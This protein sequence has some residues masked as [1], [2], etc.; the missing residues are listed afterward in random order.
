MAITWTNDYD[1]QAW[2]GLSTQL[3]H[4][5]GVPAASD[6]ATTGYT[7]TPATFGLQAIRDFIISGVDSSSASTN[8]TTMW[9]WSYN[10]AT[11]KLQVFGTGT[12]AG[13]AFNEAAAS[14][15]LSAF[16]VR[17]LIGGY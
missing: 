8:F 9:Q 3:R 6:Y 5:K 12:A 4:A 13:D 15:D 16:T 11:G 17:V 2:L 7:I 1:S 14:T 10:H